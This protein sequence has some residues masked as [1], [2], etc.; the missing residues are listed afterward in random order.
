MQQQQETVGELPLAGRREWIGLAVL[1]LPALL[2]ALDIGVLSAADRRGRIR[3][4]VC[5]GYLPPLRRH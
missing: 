3:M 1:A 4:R 5:P 2:V